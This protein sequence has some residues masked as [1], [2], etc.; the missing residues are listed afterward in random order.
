MKHKTPKINTEAKVI[1]E[2]ISDGVFTVDLD[3]RITY[4]NKAAELITGVPSKEAIGKL[5]S[6][7]F[8]ASMCETDCALR[9]TIVNKKPIINRTAFIINK[10]GARVPIGVS[11]AILKDNKG[12]IIG[13][14]ETFRDLSLV[15]EL[16][17]ELSYRFQI[18][19]IISRSQAMMRIFDILPQVAASDATVLIHGETGTGKELLAKA[20]HNLGT[21]K[22]NPFIAINCAA[23]PDSLL[24]SELF[25][26]VKGAFT[27][28]DRD[29]PGR[30][31]L[32]EGGTLFLDEIG[33][34]SSAM[35]V[36]LL[37]FLQDRV[38]EP[39]G[40]PVT[41]HANV[42]IIAATHRNLVSLVQKGIFREDLFYRIN[43]IKLELPP[44]RERKEDIPI[45]VDH[46]IDRFNRIYNKK[47]VGI[48]TEAMGLL[49]AHTYPGNIRELENIIERAVILC[50]SEY[51][52]SDY[53]PIELTG[54]GTKE[55]LKRIVGGTLKEYVDF[56]EAQAIKE[57]IKKCNGNKTAAAKL[58]GVHKTT[59]FRKI[60]LL[61]I[62]L[63]TFIKKG[64]T[65]N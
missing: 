56:A 50:R 41:K 31:A 52:T 11:T 59:F 39:L 22:E 34:I 58:L 44:L 46:F 37:R 1:L 35:Q 24:E 45:L 2:S 13:G 7:V 27:G 29:K 60:R 18:G 43:V 4:F 47:I 61:G 17:K 15:E 53:L 62:A 25:G 23:L 3:W 14:V 21:R 32:A 54:I 64:N 48:T 5:C 9:Q 65:S 16:R 26:Y 6:E 55:A 30:F 42:R 57:A 19:D 63:P 36:R 49:M 12:K 40:S 8:K 10:Q 51:I 20:I 28:A 38:Y 33:D